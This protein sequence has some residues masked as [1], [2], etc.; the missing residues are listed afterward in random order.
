MKTF[1]LAL[2]LI[3]GVL[4]AGYVETQDMRADKATTVDN[5]Y[6]F[7]HVPIDKTHTLRMFEDGSFIVEYIDGTSEEGCVPNK[8]CND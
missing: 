3:A 8:L 6:F 2:I 1:L 5:N 4:L 7:Q